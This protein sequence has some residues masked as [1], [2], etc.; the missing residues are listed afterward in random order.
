MLLAVAAA[1]LVAGLVKGVIGMGLPTVG[2]GLMSLLVAPAQAAALVVAPSLVTNVWQSVAGPY[3]GALVRRLWSLFVGIS[4]GIWLGAGLITGGNSGRAAVGLGLCLLVY[5][6]VG[7]SAVQVKVPVR[8]EWWLSPLIGVVTGLITGATGVFVIPAVP[9]LQALALDRE[10]LVQALGLSFLVSTLALAAML[11]KAGILGGSLALLSL[12][13]V[14]PALVGM[15]L[16]QAIRG[17]VS[18]NT[19]RTCFFLGMLV[20]GLHLA[21]R[22]LF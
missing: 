3:L 10:E 1:F 14:V 16:G 9:Y 6:L 17:R 21:A 18:P 20:L 19:F 5:A 8:L 7:L 15:R 22:P 13:A 11:T 4:F 12:V 2:V